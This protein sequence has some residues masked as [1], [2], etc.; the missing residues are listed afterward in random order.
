MAI[1]WVLS[2][3]MS[4]Y[5]SYDRDVVMQAVTFWSLRVLAIFVLVTALLSI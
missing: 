1:D 4:I 5:R 2:G 3:E